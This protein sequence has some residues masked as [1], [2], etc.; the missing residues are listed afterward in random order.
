MEVTVAMSGRIAFIEIV[1]AVRRHFPSIHRTVI[2]TKNIF[3]CDVDITV[4]IV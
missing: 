4:S 1:S 3:T 2:D